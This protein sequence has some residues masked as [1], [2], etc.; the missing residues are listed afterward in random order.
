MAR[1]VAGFLSHALGQQF[2]IE[3]KS[4]AGGNIGIE[5]AARSEPDGYTLLMVPVGVVARPHVSDLKVDRVQGSG[6]CDR[7]VAPAT[8]YRCAC[9][10][11]NPEID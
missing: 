2:Y 6:L 5:A 4:S 9:L 8:R 1:P 7:I 11:R 3:N 10:A